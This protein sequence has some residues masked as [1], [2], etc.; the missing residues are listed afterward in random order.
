MQTSGKTSKISC[1]CLSA[2]LP[3]A[4]NAEKHTV[5]TITWLRQWTDYLFSFKTTRPAGFRFTAGQFARLGVHKLGQIK[6]VWRAY[7]MVSASYDEHLEFYSIVV[8]GGEFTTELHKLRVGD[9][10]LVDKAPYGFLT[11]DRFAAGKHLWLLAT[12]TGLA[13]FV[14]ILH[15]L[16]IWERFEKIV[17]V[18]SVREPAE[19]VYR[20]TIESLP[21]HPYFGAAA[22]EKLVYVP[23]I[24][25]HAVAGIL[26]ARVTTLIENGQ[27]EQA[28]GLAINAQDSRIMLCGNPSMVDDTRTALKARGLRTARQSAPGGQIAVENYW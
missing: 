24:T 25:R 19:L 1:T 13:P 27:L 16:D 15:E 12:G 22:R 4:N 11:L 6:P 2:S 23:V 10:L 17:T 3:S 5:Q 20:D 21:N 9:P 28:A 26:N 14:S 7:S 18:H 8:P